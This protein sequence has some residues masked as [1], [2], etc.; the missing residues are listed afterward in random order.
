[1]EIFIKWQLKTQTV[2]TDQPSFQH[3]IWEHRNALGGGKKAAKKSK[4]LF[5]VGVLFT[6]PH[7]FTSVAG[8]CYV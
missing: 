5:L 8:A 7:I 3:N 6:R 1:M 2:L 4:A